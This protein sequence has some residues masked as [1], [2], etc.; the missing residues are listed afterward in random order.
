MVDKVYPW[1]DTFK[2][3]EANYI[4][5][6]GDTSAVGSY[7]AN[8]YGLYDMAGNVYEW[9]LDSYDPDFYAK[10]PYRDPVSGKPIEVILDTYT[11]VAWWTF[12]PVV[13]GGSWA[14]GPYFIRVATRGSI[15][16]TLSRDNNGFRCVRSVTDG[17]S[18]K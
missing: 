2:G 10:S 14:S 12:R 16:P 15:V 9:C 5:N 11:T 18:Q 17:Y 3:A 1:G 13:R 6:P 4:G 8:G 7:P